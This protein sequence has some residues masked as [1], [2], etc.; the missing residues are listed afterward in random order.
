MV[1]TC[2]DLEKP[3]LRLTSVSS[4]IPEAIISVILLCKSKGTLNSWFGLKPSKFRS[5]KMDFDFNF[6]GIVE[7]LKLHIW[8]NF[9][10][11]ENFIEEFR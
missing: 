7:S 2:Q 3:Y 1:G 10:T 4:S 11:Q 8:P 5:I 9:E 6:N